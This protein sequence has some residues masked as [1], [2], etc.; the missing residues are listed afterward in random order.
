M[1]TEVFREQFYSL[2]KKQSFLENFVLPDYQGQCIKNILSHIGAVFGVGPQIYP[3][4]YLAE[5]KGIE[6]VV[7]FIFDGLGYNRLVHY[8][9]NHNGTLM[10][11]AQKG[12]LKPLTTVFPSTTSTVLTSIFSGLTPAEHQILGYHMFSKKYGVVYNTLDMKPIFG[13]NSRVEL[14]RDYIRSIKP[15]LPNLKENGVKT[16][17]LTKA[18][19]AG[20]GLSEIIHCNYDL[21]AYLLETDMFV[22]LR[23]AL[24]QR[25]LALIIVYHS[26]VDTLAHKYGAYSEEVTFELASV[27]HNIRLFID[28]LSQQT[29]KETLMVLAADHGLAD[30]NQ[31]YYLRDYEELNSRL[32]LP[33]VGDGRATY[34]STKPDQKTA[35]ETAFTRNIGGFKLLPSSELINK[36]AFGTAVDMEGLKEKVGDFTALSSSQRIIEYPFYEDDRNREQLGAHGGMTPEE[37]IVPLLS[38]RLSNYS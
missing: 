22:Q 33:P 37:M 25:G 18:A 29:K 21:V 23:K 26:G 8:I 6:K 12:T 2:L 31:P 11:L 10:E 5:M 20:S 34:L 4:D 17:V 36:G 38:V 28:S 7:L 27:E 24:E 35:F 9:G 32:M 15:T 3:S 16:I 13:Y 19:I 1:S 14:S 30:A